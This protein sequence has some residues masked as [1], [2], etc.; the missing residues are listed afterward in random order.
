ML[1]LFQTYVW[2]LSAV[3]DVSSFRCFYV[4]SWSVVILPIGLICCPVV[5]ED[6]KP[7]DR[8]VSYSNHGYIS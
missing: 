6:G 4:L 7:S 2:F 1:A 5:S 8:K 3:H